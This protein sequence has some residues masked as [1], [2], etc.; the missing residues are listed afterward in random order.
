M[1]ILLVF[2]QNSRTEKNLLYYTDA[3]NISNQLCGKW[4]LSFL[5]DFFSIFRLTGGVG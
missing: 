3:E 5:G 2:R 4:A 1:Q